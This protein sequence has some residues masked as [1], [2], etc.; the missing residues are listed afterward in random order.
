MVSDLV[1][2]ARGVPKKIP[3]KIKLD[4][5]QLKQ[6]IHGI[7]SIIFSLLAFSRRW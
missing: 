3:D 4:E 5:E 1:W 7:I 6:L 2:I